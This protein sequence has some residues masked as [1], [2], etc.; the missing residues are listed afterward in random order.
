MPK[1]SDLPAVGTEAYRRLSFHEQ[2]EIASLQLFSPEEYDQKVGKSSVASPSAG[3]PDLPYPQQQ[4]EVED[5]PVSFLHKYWAGYKCS[6]REQWY[7]NLNGSRGITPLDEY[8]YDVDWFVN[9]RAFNFSIL[10]LTPAIHYILTWVR[11]L[12]HR[13]DTS[14]KAL[15]DSCKVYTYIAHHDD[16]LPMRKNRRGQWELDPVETYLAALKEYWSL[17]S[18]DELNEYHP[19]VEPCEELDYISW[20]EFSIYSQAKYRHR[21][22]FYPVVPNKLFLARRFSIKEWDFIDKRA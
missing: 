1:L 9:L 11:A 19:M 13:N 8:G 2:L 16:D 21:R 10:S 18:F 22:W 6:Y 14:E 12:A 5:L 17:T 20:H 7:L 15:L 3:L 4:Y